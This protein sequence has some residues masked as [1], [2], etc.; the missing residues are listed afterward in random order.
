MDL[1]E[2]DKRFA[3]YT[4]PLVLKRIITKVKINVDELFQ[5]EYGS[6]SSPNYVLTEREVYIAMTEYYTNRNINIAPSNKAI[7]EKNIEI[8][9][10]QY[11]SIVYNNIKQQL[12]FRRNLNS[13]P[14]PNQ[15]PV[16]T[17][18]KNNYQ[19]MDASFTNMFN[20]I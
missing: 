3:I 2:E 14:V 6:S 16:G 15:Y 20:I 13:R 17:T 8:F 11:T 4:H 9:V 19:G 10:E 1:K 18:R 7:I 12:R 5:E